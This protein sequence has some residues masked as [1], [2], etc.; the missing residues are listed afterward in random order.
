[1]PNTAGR[2]EHD[3][4]VVVVGS[5]PGG[6]TLA[7]L[8]ARSGV[9]V[10][11][12]ERQRDLDRSFR[13]FLF[14]PQVLRTFDQMG[15][16]ES[17]LDLDHHTVHTPSVEI[18]DKTIPVINLSTFDEQYDYGISMEQPALLRRLIDHADEYDEF[19][20]QDATTV[21]DLIVENGRIVGVT[22]TDREASEEF[23]LRSR[24]VVGADGRYSTVRTAADID[25]GLLESQIELIWFKLPA[26][27]VRGDLEAR[28]NDGGVLGYFGIGGQESQLGYFVEKDAYTQLQSA[29]IE[30]FYERITAVDPTLDGPLQEH[31]TEYA[32]TTLLH[33]EPGVSDQWIDDGLLLVGDAAHVASPIGGQGNGLAITDAV[34]AHSVLCE[35]LTETDGILSQESLRLYE[36]TR[37]PTVETVLQFQRRSERGLSAFVRRRHQVPASVRK[38]LIRGLVSLAF[39]SPLSKRLGRQFAW[40]SW[41][42]VDTSQFVDVGEQEAGVSQSG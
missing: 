42:P 7:F 33:I 18:Y 11:L 13:G 2:Q 15:V 9:D 4:E 35:A 40:G 20:Y 39:R 1:M 30:R 31:V 26:D 21:Q 36:Q 6:T 3:S 17:V 14:Q 37:R 34:A 41:E 16:L 29:G 23:E 12:L 27:A 38:P 24:L 28:F 10:T 25:P 19:E 32:D 8:L 22:G 5:G